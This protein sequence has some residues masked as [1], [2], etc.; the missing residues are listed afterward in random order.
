MGEVLP[1][2]DR[3]EP[4]VQHDNGWS[5]PIARLQPE[6]LKALAVDHDIG[7]F[8]C[9]RRVHRRSDPSTMPSAISAHGTIHCAATSSGNV[10]ELA[11]CFSISPTRRAP[12]SVS[13]LSKR[14][15]PSQNVSL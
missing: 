2:S 13:K 6:S 3:T 5:R 11:S 7:Q 8:R 15:P 1:Q 12:S 9:K 4:F 10:P 14:M